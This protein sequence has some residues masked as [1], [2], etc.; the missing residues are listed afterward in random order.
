MR[1]S[2]S[3]VVVSL[4]DAGT[5]LDRFVKSHLPHVPHSVV[6][7]LIRT[8]KVRLVQD[9][10]RRRCSCEQRVEEGQRY[11][12]PPPVDET[13][14][15]APPPLPALELDV[16]F[17]D[18]TMVVVNKP[19]GLPMH[20]GTGYTSP[21]AVVLRDYLDQLDGAV[22]TASRLDKDTSGIVVATRGRRDGRFLNEAWSSSRKGYVALVEGFPKE[23]QGISEIDMCHTAYRVV[24]QADRGCLIWAEPREGKKHQVRIALSQQGC[25]VLGDVK[26]G[27]KKRRPR[28]YLHLFKVKME[29]PLTR[30]QMTLE[31]PLQNDFVERVRMM[32]FDWD[33]LRPNCEFI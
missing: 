11:E 4:Q 24:G 28:V 13:I 27:A 19:S 7:K 32:G 26:Y 21:D 1:A 23:Q 15:I 29:H 10:D 20:R 18:E 14:D 31:A 9:G 12:I 5:R 16:L 33:H 8:R 22:H 2:S 6:M 25:P 30:S 3:V 17:Q